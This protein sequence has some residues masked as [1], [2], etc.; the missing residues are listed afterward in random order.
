MAKTYTAAGTVVAGDVATAA[1]FNVVTA[2]IN[3]L[4]VP[5]ACR[6]V[7]SA[8]Q[9]ISN[10]TNTDVAFTAGA[11]FDTDTMFSAGSNT[12]ITIQ[13]TGIYVVSAVAQFASSATGVRFMSIG[14]NAGYGGNEMELGASGGGPTTISV[15]SAIS[16][17]EADYLTLRVYQSSGLAINLLYG[18]LSAAWV[19]RTA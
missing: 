7:R 8:S 3:N 15:T 19:G 1:A 17:T 16:L 11:A 18:T 10:T 5:P 2:D 14:T 9:S 6:V 4:I 12:R 13:T